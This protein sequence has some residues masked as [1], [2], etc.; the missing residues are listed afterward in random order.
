MP[1]TRRWQQRIQAGCISIAGTVTTDC[2]QP[3][4]WGHGR[5]RGTAGP[6]SRSIHIMGCRGWCQ[7]VCEWDGSLSVVFQQAL[8][9]AVFLTSKGSLECSCGGMPQVPWGP[10]PSICGCGPWVGFCGWAHA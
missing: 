7:L 10:T 3:L 2:Q 6:A 5:G 1:R 4:K 8:L 9:M